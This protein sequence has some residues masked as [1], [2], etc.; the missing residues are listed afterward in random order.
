MSSVLES[1]SPEE[2]YKLMEKLSTYNEGSII[3][4]DLVNV[5]EVGVENKQPLLLS[6]GINFE[7][8]VKVTVDSSWQFYLTNLTRQVCLGI[9]VIS[10]LWIDLTWFYHILNMETAQ[11]YRMMKSGLSY[12]QLDILCIRKEI[13]SSL[14]DILSI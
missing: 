5:N 4:L 1:L 12:L 9:L 6:R 11:N 8:V 14:K 10:L 7:T 3:R 2:F 13:S